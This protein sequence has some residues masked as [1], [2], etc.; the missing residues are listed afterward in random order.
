MRNLLIFIIIQTWRCHRPNHTVPKKAMVG[1]AGSVISKTISFSAK[2]M[3]N[4][5]EIA[6]I[7]MDSN[8][9]LITISTRL[10]SQRRFVN[11]PSTWSS[12]RWRTWR[13]KVTMPYIQIS[14]N[15]PRSNRYLWSN[16]R[17]IHCDTEG[18]G[19]NERKVQQGRLWSLPSSS[20]RSATDASDRNELV[21]SNI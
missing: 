8:R 13:W 19:H 21:N 15:I 20:L 6:S 14:F 5:S 9:C 12:R 17:E 10:S 1:S 2:S 3:K 11:D 4:T 7:F 16:S 18:F